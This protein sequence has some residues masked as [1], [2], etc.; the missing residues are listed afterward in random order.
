MIKYTCRVPTWGA[1]LPT[2][3]TSP[4]VFSFPT[5]EIDEY[6]HELPIRCCKKTQILVDPWPAKQRR[7]TLAPQQEQGSEIYLQDLPGSSDWSDNIGGFPYRFHHHWILMNFVLGQHGGRSK[8]SW[9]NWP[10]NCAFAGNNHLFWLEQG[11]QSDVFVFIDNCRYS[12]MQKYDIPCLLLTF[13]LLHL[14]I[15]KQNL[16]TMFFFQAPAT[17]LLPHCTL[18]LSLIGHRLFSYWNA[19]DLC[20]FEVDC[21]RPPFTVF[22]TG[23]WCTQV[24]CVIVLENIPINKQIYVWT[25]NWA[26]HISWFP[27]AVPWGLAC[28]APDTSDL[29]PWLCIFVILAFP[30]EMLYPKNCSWIPWIHVHYSSNTWRLWVYTSPTTP[31][32]FQ[33]EIWR[34]D[35]RLHQNVRRCTVRPLTTPGSSHNA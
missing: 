29:S 7:S 14:I 11:C 24:L 17:W 28:F 32:F 25:Y 31:C 21:G 1:P 20:N 2:N 30:R 19:T 34:L 9:S 23:I 33:Y 15:P 3:E 12:T 5:A 8:P 6:V 27:V 18:L 4:T 35:I 13:V 16:Y 26:R 10:S 22:F